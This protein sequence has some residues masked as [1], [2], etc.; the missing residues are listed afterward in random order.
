MCDVGSV[1]TNHG[2]DAEQPGS[3]SSWT[4][5]T[6]HSSDHELP[7]GSTH[8]FHI[9][10]GVTN[11]GKGWRTVRGPANMDPGNICFR[12][13]LRQKLMSKGDESIGDD[14]KRKT[15]RDCERWRWLESIG[16]A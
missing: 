8:K 14:W 2:A 16:T 11:V 12:E 6:R 7:R 3:K 15:T 4:N 5:G 10:L 1:S 9:R 13:E